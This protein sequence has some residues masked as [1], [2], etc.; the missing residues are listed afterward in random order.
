MDSIF[1][2]VYW[3]V[4][5]IIFVLSLTIFMRYDDLLND[6]YERLFYNNKYVEMYKDNNN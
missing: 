4:G 5:A 6:R 3:S 1:K 2:V